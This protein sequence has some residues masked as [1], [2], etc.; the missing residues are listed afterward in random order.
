MIVRPA[1]PSDIAFAIAN[2]SAVSAAEYAAVAADRNTS[3]AYIEWRLIDALPDA[4]FCFALCPP[5]TKAPGAMMFAWRGEAGEARLAGLT[6]SL[7]DEIKRPFWIWLARRLTA[8]IDRLAFRSVLTVT[9]EPRAWVDRLGRLGYCKTGREITG[10]VEFI[11]LERLR[12]LNR[13]VDRLEA[14]LVC[15]SSDQPVVAG[16]E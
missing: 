16:T 13:A 4:L 5:A 15:L 7:F 9:A 8:E 6:T 10:G 1:T 14:G 3:L 12:P 2:L 11:D